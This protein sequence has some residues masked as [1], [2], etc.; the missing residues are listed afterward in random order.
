M[1]SARHQN[2]IASA[3]DS[4]KSIV[5]I[6]SGQC[7]RVLSIIRQHGPVLSLTLT[8]DYAIP[9]TAA[10]VHDLRCAGWNIQTYIHAD[11]VFRGQVRKR[12]AAYSLGVPEWPRP[13]FFASDQPAD[14]R[15]DLGCAS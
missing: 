2:S 5:P 13:G 4:R 12:V 11:V 15:L 14:A 10:R 3:Q 6:V 8:A 9:E 1:K 7:A